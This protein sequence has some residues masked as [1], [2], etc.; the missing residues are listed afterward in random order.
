MAKI[1]HNKGIGGQNSEQGRARF[2][3]DVIALRPQAVLIY[4]G[5]NDTLNEPR[6][7]DVGRFIENLDWMVGRSLGQGIRPV[8]CTI[9]HVNPDRLFERHARESYGEEGPNGKIDRYNAALR[10]LVRRRHVALADFC[11]SFDRAGGPTPE[12]CPDGVHLSPTGYRILA[13]S[14]CNAGE[15]WTGVDTVV[16]LGDSVTAGLNVPGG[17]TA[18][19]ETYPAVLSRLLGEGR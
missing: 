19:G 14:F 9:Q 7:L 11:E 5:L 12:H 1:V 16:C 4:F 15:P 3:A 10:D 17:G 8:L 6:F 18:T 13:R 2:D